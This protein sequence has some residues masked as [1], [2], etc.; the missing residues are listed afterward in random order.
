MSLN[1]KKK[2]KLKLE[3]HT[4]SIDV[5]HHE[6]ALYF[7]EL[8]DSLPKKI[9]QLKTMKKKKLD[10]SSLEREI[11]DITNRT[12]ENN[13]YLETCNI[14]KEYF[15]IEE[16][17][18]KTI[19]LNIENLQSTKINERKQE[20]TKEYYSIIGLKY[21]EDL[22]KNFILLCQ[23]CDTE[24]KENGEKFLVCDNCG[25]TDRDQLIDGSSYQDIQESNST[26]V[27]NYKRINYFLEWINQIQAN[28]NVS[29]EEAVLD[30]VKEELR[31]RRISDNT[32]L[33]HSL[34][35]N[36]LKQINRNK[37]Y[38][39]IPLI[40]SKICGSQPLKIPSEIVEKMKSMFM[41]I[42]YPF[43]TLKDPGR[44]NFFSYPYVFYKFS[45][46]LGMYEYLGH[47]S[48][49]KSRTKLL[50]QDMLWKKIVDFLR[51]S[52]GDELWVFHPSC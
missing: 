34:M 50:K 41:T 1:L 49:L 36:V 42:Q 26:Y 20:L 39:H 29:I 19:E 11:F 44:I 45:E 18:S 16:E 52:T 17:T 30:E 10:T 7:S 6:K 22:I 46:L 15:E 13:Y 9:K 4:K 3:Q 21:H 35:K 47:F 40:I 43:D 12:Q 27:F 23:T 5:L 2:K 37:F 38:E 14:L 24:M 48:L 8:Q 33:S 31:K 25:S 51:Q 32:K 28:E